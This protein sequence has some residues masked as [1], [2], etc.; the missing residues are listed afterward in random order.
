MPVQ[1]RD[2]HGLDPISWWP[3]AMGV[4]VGLLLGILLL[5]LLA[6]I[7]RYLI[8]YPPGSWRSAA[9]AA[10]R[11][12][13]RKRHQLTPKETASRLSELLRRIAMARFGREGLASLTG[14]EWLER[15][16]LSD[17]SGFPWEEKGE[18]LITLPYAPDDQ[19]V[20]PGQIDELIEATLDLIGSSREDARRQ[21]RRWL[22]GDDV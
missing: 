6:V 12:L 19:Q 18:I 21:Q 13:Q 3:P 16:Q 11:A 9:R 10:V 15:L 14:R 4:W 17:S 8:L 22:R 20:K 7:V 1:L 5:L 2:I